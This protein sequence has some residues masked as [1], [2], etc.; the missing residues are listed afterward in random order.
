M[1]MQPKK[2]LDLPWSEKILPL[3]RLLSPKKKE[4]GN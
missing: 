2:N 1:A 3:N 4:V